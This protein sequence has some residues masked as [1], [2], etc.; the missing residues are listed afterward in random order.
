MTFLMP[1]VLSLGNRFIIQ[2]M[3][4]EKNN[5]MRES[6]K[7]MSLTTN[8][9]ISSVF[10][11]YTLFAVFAG[12]SFALA[13]T[14]FFALFPDNPIMNPIFFGIAVMLFMI[15]QI[16]YCMALSTLFSDSKLAN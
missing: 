6:L 16:P 3:V 1:L 11:T 15:A 14:N 2:G 5:K 7:L 10:L 8:N 12:V 9:Y 13:F 4:D